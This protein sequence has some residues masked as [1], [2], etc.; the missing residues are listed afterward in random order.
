LRTGRPIRRHARHVGK[1]HLLDLP[2]SRVEG[3][4]STLGSVRDKE[5]EIPRINAGSGDER[6]ILNRSVREFETHCMGKVEYD[7]RLQAVY[8]AGRQ[9]SP[10]ALQ[11]WMEAF[12]GH[13]PRQGKM[14]F[15]R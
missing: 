14:E 1:T 7:A 3:N 2:S 8:A 11:T 10:D 4:E 13:L 15:P 6:H 12:A 5:H 9:M